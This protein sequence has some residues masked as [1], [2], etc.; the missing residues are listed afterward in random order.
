M[1]IG[2]FIWMTYLGIH[3]YETTALLT[4]FTPLSIWDVVSVYTIAGS[5]YFIPFILHKFYKGT[6]A[7]LTKFAQIYIQVMHGIQCRGNVL[8]QVRLMLYLLH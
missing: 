1:M 4:Y 8:R 7:G 5:A 6:E 3:P 2:Y